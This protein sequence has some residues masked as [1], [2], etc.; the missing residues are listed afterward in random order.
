VNDFVNPEHRGV[1]L[2]AGFKDLMEV[3]DGKKKSEHES[4]RKLRFQE[5]SANGLIHVEKSLDLLLNSHAEDPLLAFGEGRNLS[6]FVLCRE[7]NGLKAVFCFSGGDLILERTVREVFAEA[8]TIPG[9]EVR[10]S[11]TGHQILTYPVPSARSQL[12]KVVR[13]LLQRAYEIS[14]RDELT[15]IIRA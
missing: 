10:N 8:G 12:L 11:D 6:P 9:S 7:R 3:L 1:N 2:P 13:E 14:D 4:G 5:F 15:I